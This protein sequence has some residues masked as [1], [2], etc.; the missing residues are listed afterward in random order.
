PAKVS[1]I[2][3]DARGNY[4]AAL[5]SERLSTAVEKA[6]LQA[7]GANSGQNIDNATRQQIKSILNSPKSRRGY[8]GEE[9]RQM[10]RIVQGT[11]AGDA[12]RYIGNLLGGGGGLG[13]VV[14]A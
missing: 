14:T 1:S 5:R 2:W 6:E 8:S 11:F 13:T 12:A 3:S 4:A 10:Q 9:L 7:G